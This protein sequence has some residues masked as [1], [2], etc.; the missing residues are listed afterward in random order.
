MACG[1]WSFQNR[2]G[3][4]K[5]DGPVGSDPFERWHRGP[6]FLGV[7]RASGENPV[8]FEAIKDILK[9]AL[10]AACLYVALG[11]YVRRKGQ[12]WSAF[13]DKRRLRVLLLLILAITAIKVMEDVV[14][15]ESGPVDETL[16]RFV[17]ANVPPTLNG[18]FEAATFTGS[19]KVMVLL[20]TVLVAALLIARRRFEAALVAVSVLGAGA[21]VF[22]L[23]ALVGRARPTLWETE[24]YWGSSFPSGHTL[25]TT[26]FASAA[27]MCVARIRPAWR[28]PAAAIAVLWVLAVALSR[29]V[30]GVHWP[31]DVLAAACI[32]VVLPLVVDMALELVRKPTGTA[33]ADTPPELP[34]SS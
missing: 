8:A 15:R 21:V 23:K 28:L 31:T 6:A 33:S 19:D 2:G 29:L 32:G 14:T 27:V 10:I 34:R 13:L 24:W 5:V 4:Q 12:A 11:Y 30:L 17:H 3:I 9:L 7:A 16:L 22:I 1:G 26:A 20:S 18:F 25:A